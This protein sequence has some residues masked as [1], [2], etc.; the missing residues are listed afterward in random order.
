MF[1]PV[2]D[3]GMSQRDLYV[4]SVALSWMLDNHNGIVWHNG[5]THYFN[6]YLGFSRD[7]D[8]AVVVLSNTPSNYRFSSSD[9]GSA[10]LKQLLQNK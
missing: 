5:A 8:K 2:V 1:E 10:L 3:V 7:A 9:I 6:S 4:D